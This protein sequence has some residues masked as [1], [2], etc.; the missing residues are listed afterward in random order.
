THPNAAQ[1]GC[2][3]D[4]AC[5]A[6]ALSALAVP[7]LTPAFSPGVHRY[8]VPAPVGGGTWAR[9]TLC[10]GTKTLYV[11]GNQASS[12]ARVG[13]WLGSGSATVAVYQRWTPVGT[14]T[15]TVDP[16]LPPA[17]L[18]E[19]LASLS[20]P[21]LSPPFDPAVTHYTAP[22][23]PTSTVPVTAA[24]ASPGA[25]TLWI[26]SLLTGSGAT[27]TTWA[28]LGNVVDVTVTEGWLEIGHYYVTIV[29]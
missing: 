3:P 16:S 2:E 8:R 21:G 17:P 6:S 23:R 7:G 14:Y 20:I 4:A 26:E 5:D 22:A 9:A 24:L 19:G 15:I 12:G 25:S 13:L 11:G 18:T 10:D 29:R 1:T 28:P 27:R